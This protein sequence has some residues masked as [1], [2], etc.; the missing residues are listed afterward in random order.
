MRPLGVTFTSQKCEPGFSSAEF[1]FPSVGLSATEPLKDIFPSAIFIESIWIFIEG[2]I[3]RE[4]VLSVSSGVK[5]ERE[6]RSLS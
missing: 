3:S 5:D 2:E 6:P 4:R 1:N